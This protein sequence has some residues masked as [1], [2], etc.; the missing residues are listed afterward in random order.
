MII[1][2]VHT[3][4]SIAPT[5]SLCAQFYILVTVDVMKEIIFEYIEENITNSHQG[6]NTC[7]RLP[8]PRIVFL[9]KTLRIIIEILY[10]T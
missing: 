10:T 7:V 4:T 8:S 9:L 2:W 1:N 3:P 5:T 6:Y